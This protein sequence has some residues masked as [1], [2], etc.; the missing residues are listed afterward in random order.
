M[1][2]ITEIRDVYRT[3]WLAEYSPYRLGSV[4]GR[5]DTEFEYWR[6]LQARTWKR[7]GLTSQDRRYRRW[8]L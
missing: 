4:M 2:P 3:L 6:K 7:N 5:F 1:D 8:R